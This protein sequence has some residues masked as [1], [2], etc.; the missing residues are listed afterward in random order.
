MDADKDGTSCAISLNGSE[1]FMGLDKKSGMTLTY[2]RSPYTAL[3][4]FYFPKDQSGIVEL[5]GISFR[6]NNSNVISVQVN[7]K[8]KFDNKTLIR[9][10]GIQQVKLEDKSS[11][12][13][14]LR[15]IE[16]PHSKLEV[17]VSA[18]VSTEQGE[19][20]IIWKFELIP[21]TEKE[22]RNDRLDSIMSV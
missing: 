8:E 20:D 11:A 17:T 14:L 3:V 21:F 2:F 18:L 13:F 16:I 6:E 22:L 7:R 10:G 15:Q 19:Y 9:K 1:Q 5:K 4:T 12:S